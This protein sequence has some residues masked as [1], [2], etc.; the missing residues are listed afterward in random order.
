MLQERVVC[1]GFQR[2]SCNSVCVDI[3]IGIFGGMASPLLKKPDT[4]AHTRKNMLRYCWEKC[5]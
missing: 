5:P 1:Q 2:G 3:C 4:V